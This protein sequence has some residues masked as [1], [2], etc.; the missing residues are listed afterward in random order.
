MR[1]IYLVQPNYHS[2]FND[3][4][5]YWLPYS[6]GTIWCYAYQ[7][8]IVQDNFNLKDI[9]F[10]RSNIE[11]LVDTITNSAIF[12]FSNYI[13]NW[14][15]NN[16]L[17]RAIKEKFPSSKII[18]GGPQVTNRPLETGFFKKYPYVDSVILGEGEIG[19]EQILIDLHNNKN[20]KIYN[21]VRVDDLESIPSPYTLGFFDNILKENPTAIWS[22]VL[23]T[24]RGCPYACTFCDWG[25]LTYSKVKKFPLDRVFEEI[26]WMGKNNIDIM[27]LTD[28]NFGIFK[29]R[30]L[31]IAEK[32]CQTKKM[33]NAPN[34]ISMS[35]AK[36]S[37]QNVVNIV[38]LFTQHNLSRG[39][40]ISFQSLDDRV[41]ESIKR[42][43]MDI[44]RAEEIFQLLEEKQLNYYSE[45]ILGLPE[46]TLETWKEGLIKIISKGQHQC[47]DV[48][49]TSMLENSELN[50]PS[51]REKYDLKVVTV[52]DVT[53][54]IYDDESNILEK[55]DIVYSTNTLSNSE[56]I[57]ALMFSWIIVNLHNYGWTQIYSRFLNNTNQISYRDFYNDLVESV[58]KNQLGIISEKYQDYKNRSVLYFN[59][60]AEFIAQKYSHDLMRDVQPFFYQNATMIEE[61]IFDFV[62]AKYN[63]QSDIL[64]NLKELQTHYVSSYNK[65]Y[66][67][68]CQIDV[69]ILD[70]ILLNK[71]YK[72]NKVTVSVNVTDSFLDQEDF[73]KKL[74]TRRRNGWGK[75]KIK[76][77]NGHSQITDKR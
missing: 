77:K 54:T 8:K 57:D 53:Y 27:T 62:K 69:G 11:Q 60:N 36:N 76:E 29:E 61:T 58:V 4:I 52:E 71:I 51:Q 32:I 64:N 46:E 31:A 3:Q 41:L 6:V 10:K 75:T 2:I 49:L 18:F 23:E 12:A 21:A 34:N 30:D 72:K 26:E 39:M 50:Q 9:F 67:Y 68:E 14:E 28:A 74:I 22:G 1:D 55:T 65:V 15:Y 45:L 5:N 24:N 47:I 66:P 70:T 17:A 48:H 56:L 37:N 7:N 40:T 13:W 59:N 43:N 16:R 44:N 38:E 42:K 73:L 63:I 35:Y 19:F 25:S 33:Y 20:K